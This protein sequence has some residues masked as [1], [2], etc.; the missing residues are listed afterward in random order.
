MSFRKREN[1]LSSELR[2]GGTM[3]LA[4]IANLLFVA[5]ILLFAAASAPAQSL[6]NGAVHGTV[7]DTTNAVM[8]NVKLTLTNTSTGLQ[9]QLT[10]EADGGYDFENVPPGQYNLTAEAS[11]FA[12]KTVKAIEITVGGSITEDV[13]M[14]PKTQTQSVEVTAD[15]TQVVDTSTAGV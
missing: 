13:T 15:T 10:T 2:V 3:K 12:T 14:P 11:G 8:P 5:A 4:K 9:R 6:Q 1:K 7:V